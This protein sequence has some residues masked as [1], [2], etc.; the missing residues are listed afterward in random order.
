MRALLLDYWR[1]A[2]LHSVDRRFGRMLWAGVLGVGGLAIG[3]CT[4]DGESSASSV[5]YA[6]LVGVH[7]GDTHEVAIGLFCGA[8]YLPIGV[9]DATWRAEELI[10]DDKSWAPNEWWAV[11][12][13]IDGTADVL[14][15]GL[16]MESGQSRLIATANGRSVA[17]R[18]MT[19]TD[20]AN[21]CS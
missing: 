2:N 9:N 6:P 5:P 16:R 13:T 18:P 10:D 3:G 15:V 1:P 19:S 20:P 21:E 7:D 12:K 4:S 14:T 11:A 17:Y 8:D